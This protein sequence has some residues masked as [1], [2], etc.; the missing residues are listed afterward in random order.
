MLYVTLGDTHYRIERPWGDVPGSGG[1]ISDVACDDTAAMS[2]CCCA[3]IPM[4][5]AT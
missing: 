4:A 5:A 2:S 3:A 1:A